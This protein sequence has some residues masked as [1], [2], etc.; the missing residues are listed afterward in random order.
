MKYVPLHCH[1]TYSL[2]DG[3]S[4]PKQMVERLDELGLEACAL[5]DHGTISGAVDFVKTMKK[6]GKK[7]ILGC[8]FYICEGRATDKSPENKK[9]SHQVILAR[10][11]Q[12][13]KD[14]IK[15]V[16]WSNRPEQFYYKPRIDWDTLGSC[17]E[18]NFI[19]FSGHLGSTLAN[20]ILD[21]GKLKSN[22][23][24]EGS[25]W[26][27]ALQEIFGKGN[28]FIEIQMIDAR[29]N[30]LAN[31][32]GNAMRE[33]AKETKIPSVATPDA[34]Y[35][36]RE[37]VEDH[38][39]LLAT[40]IQKSL[41]QIYKEL[42]VNPNA[43]LSSFFTSDNYHI[44]SWDDLAD[45][46]NEEE[47]ENTKLI[48]DMCEDYDILNK[49]QLPEYRCPNDQKDTEYLRQLCRDGWKELIK[50]EKDDPDFNRYV[51]QIKKEL[52]VLESANLSSYFLIV[53]DICDYVRDNGWLIGPGRGSAAGCLVS[54]LLGI[55]SIDPLKHNL[56]FERFYNAGRNTADHISYPDIDIDVPRNA[57]N[58]VIQF[59]KDR[60][61][62][63]NVAQIITF[64]TMKGKAALKRVFNAYGDISFDEQNAITKNIVDENKI[65]D[66]LQEME[67]A[68]IIR[69]ALENRRKAFEEWCY[70]D[71]DNELR[72]PLADAFAQAMR[73][74]GTKIAQS[75]H[76]AGV[77]ISKGK[78]NDI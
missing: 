75:R 8:E 46:N 13:W 72:G 30:T 57:R 73:L 59:L 23:K 43:S 6:A 16:S 21:E 17:C 29:E 47:I 28:F 33:I 50:L 12:G 53:K 1:S 20:C 34:H 70:I 74:E 68:S 71:D 62:S 60:Y 3:L 77:V 27:Y 5:T 67:E 9:L 45:C 61:G 65:A 36:R 38:R 11:L 10:N 63:D 19:S 40:N 78:L 15:L 55:T 69:W 7:P 31:I 42:K 14:L 24:E 4:Q 76:P 32:V 26:A 54:Y 18:Q 35:C 41:K 49:P 52:D 39:V 2:L 44:P 37:D 58:Q 64:Q 25:S 56:L 22:W 48:A 66:E 51:D